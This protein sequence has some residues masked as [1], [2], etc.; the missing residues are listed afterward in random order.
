MSIVAVHRASIEALVKLFRQKRIGAA[1]R[2]VVRGSRFITYDIRLKNPMQYSEAMALAEPL[3]LAL[4]VKGVASYRDMGV[5]RF[6]I[7]L[8]EQYWQ[9]VTFAEMQ[10]PFQVGYLP[11]NRPIHF[12]LR[13]PN[14]LVVGVPGSGK[15]EG[16]KTILLSTL[17]QRTPERLQLALID[18]HKAIVEFDNAPHLLQEP[19][20]EPAGIT[21]TIKMLIGKLTDRKRVGEATVKAN[22]DK[23]PLVLLAV[24]EASEPGVLGTKDYPNRDNIA[25]VQQLA[26]EGRKFN[27]R[28]LLGTQKPTEADLPG[29]MS[30]FP[31][32]YVGQVT[33]ARMAA[34]FS[35][36]KEVPAHLL[37][38]NGDF[39]RSS[40]DELVRFQF[41]LTSANDYA[42]IASPII[43][44]DEPEQSR[45]RPSL[46]VEPETLAHYL[47]NGKMTL[48]MAQEQLGITRTAHEKHRDFALRVE[49]KIRELRNGE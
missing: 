25:L 16:I 3:A 2:S 26:K 42:R 37:T 19:A 4:G 13:D 48:R 8:P 9:V 49:A 31:V 10:E 7:T 46:E 22:P 28:L 1:A 33:D 45:G 15:S 34:N 24:D 11:G 27:M 12:S 23:Y 41:A 14:Q 43:Q 38:G 30:M 36:K 21:D 20:T 39:F 44:T 47:H 40:G 6:D 5:I 32:R 17:L 29:I 18:P 35:G